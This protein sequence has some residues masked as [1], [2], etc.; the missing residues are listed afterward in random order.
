M[1]IF[2]Q[3]K[4]ICRL[5]NIYPQR[6]KGQNF[7]INEEIYQD[8]I[9]NAKIDNKNVLEVGPGLGFLTA[10][11]AK[12]ARKVVAVEKDEKLVE[13]LQS[14]NSIK[15]FNN[16]EII[17][18][19]ILKFN[20]FDFF[21]S[22]DKNYHI[23]ANL[24]YNIS[25]IFLRTYLSSPFPPLSLF[26]ML[27]K[28][29]AERIIAKEPNMNLLALSVNYY[30]QAEIIKIVK[31]ENFWPI[32]QVDSALIKIAYN[33]ER[34]KDF[35]VSKDNLKEDKKFFQLAKIGF[36]A[37]RKMLKNNLS[38]GLKIDEAKILQVFK[39]INIKETCR[40]QELS[41]SDWLNLKQEIFGLD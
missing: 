25:S 11:L 14:A 26:L 13:F 1:S 20:P 40:A 23:V 39:N 41:L 34:L 24:P 36:S 16:L 5:Y 27:Q 38:L 32:P 15:N 21:Y 12:S 2:K 29:V 7:L 28:E 6:S 3:T 17:N 8:I 37:K 10:K 9:E 33:K 4:D 30:A 18:Q 35:L 31:A 22:D 19:D